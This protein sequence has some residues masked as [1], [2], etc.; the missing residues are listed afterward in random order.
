[1]TFSFLV[2][3]VIDLFIGFEDYTVALLHIFM[4]MEQRGHFLILVLLSLIL[5]IFLDLSGGT[6]F[7][8]MQ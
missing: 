2:I 8:V 6:W 4:R 3:N 7:H 1:M 5:Y